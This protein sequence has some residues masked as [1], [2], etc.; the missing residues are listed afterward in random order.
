MLALGAIVWLVTTAGGESADAGARALD[1][2]KI[3]AVMKAQRSGRNGRSLAEGPA[4]S[5]TRLAMQAPLGR[6]GSGS[7]SRA[8]ISSASRYSSSTN[9]VTG[10]PGLHGLRCSRR[11]IRG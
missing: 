1:K 6:P 9:N 2:E 7:H 4:I 5:S 8:A 3:R 10:D 11:G